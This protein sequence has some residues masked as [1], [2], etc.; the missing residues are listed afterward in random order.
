M[1][2]AE[3]GRLLAA[4]AVVEEEVVVEGGVEESGMGQAGDVSCRAGGDIGPGMTE[5]ATRVLGASL[6]AAVPSSSLELLLLLLLTWGKT[7]KGAS[8]A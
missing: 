7:G 8:A 4:V 3:A 2:R 1:R 5:L 6:V